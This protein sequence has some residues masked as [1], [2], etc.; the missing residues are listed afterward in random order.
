MKLPR[1]ILAAALLA[2]SGPCNATLSFYTMNK[3]TFHLELVSNS[4]GTGILD[5]IS[6]DG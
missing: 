5:Q 4:G 3:D 2:T 1:I 6:Q